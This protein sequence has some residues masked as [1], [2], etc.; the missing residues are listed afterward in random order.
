MSLRLI[1]RDLYRLQQAVDRL[2]KALADGQVRIEQVSNGRKLEGIAGHA[3]YH[4]T[5]ERLVLTGGRPKMIDSER[6]T[7]QGSR[8]TYY[9]RNDRLL[10]DGADSRPAVSNFR[11]R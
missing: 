6:G 5:D 1:A 10:V 2:E 7:T 3:E 11:R 9:A 4:L 8:L